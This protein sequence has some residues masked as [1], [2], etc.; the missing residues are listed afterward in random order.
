MKGCEVRRD[1]LIVPGAGANSNNTHLSR[2]STSLFEAS[3]PREKTTLH[4]FSQQLS[5]FPHKVVLEKQQV[6]EMNT[7]SLTMSHCPP[8][9]R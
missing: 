6:I 1:G 4:F 3:K 5:L 9:C 8:S 2:L 7:V